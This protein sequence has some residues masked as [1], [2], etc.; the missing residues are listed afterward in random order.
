MD[1]LYLLVSHLIGR[2]SYGSDSWEN[3]SL[4]SLSTNILPIALFGGAVWLLT[5]HWDEIYDR[6]VDQFLVTA[7]FESSNQAYGWI[8]TW[9]SSQPEWA[10]LR[11]VQVASISGNGDMFSWIHRYMRFNETS[12]SYWCRP[13]SHTKMTCRFEGTYVQIVF[14]DPTNSGGFYVPAVMIVRVLGFDRARL[15]RLL[16]EAQKMYK[17]TR[18]GLQVWTHSK[19]HGGEV[20]WE[21]WCVLGRRSIETLVL[22]EEVKARSLE[23]VREFLS[24]ESKQ[25]YKDNSLPYRRG[26]LF[27]G[28]PGSGK[29]TLIHCIANELDREVCVVTLSAVDD[30]TLP[31]LLGS[32]PEKSVVIME[33]IDVAIQDFKTA[34]ESRADATLNRDKQDTNRPHS[35]LT[36]SGLL[37]AIDGV[38]SQNGR[39]LFV[40]TNKEAALDPALTRAGRLDVHIE[41]FHAKS[42]HAAQLFRRFYAIPSAKAKEAGIS[43]S[44]ETIDV[45][46]NRFA[47]AIPDG[48]L[49]MAQL[50]NYLMSHKH[51]PQKACD[52][53][54]EWVARELEKAEKRRAQGGLATNVQIDTQAAPSPEVALLPS[55]NLTVRSIADEDQVNADVQA[56]QFRDSEIGSGS[57]TLTLPSPVAY[58]DR[59]CPQGGER[60]Q[61][62]A[63]GA[64]SAAAASEETLAGDGEAEPKHT[65]LN[66]SAAEAEGAA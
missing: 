46:A 62:P 6:I 43:H 51:E 65:E 14:F 47:E 40:T 11:R 50:Q 9:A 22:D 29:T 7:S 59:I 42:A 53:A 64:L 33:D 13:T 10:K 45:L 21:N 55:A 41:F 35:G 56:R 28:V 54:R 34:S 44:S 19:A 37:N 31:K 23:D 26:Y 16:D 1:V 58:T 5:Q 20:E 48:A 61:D 2:L 25:W 3:F 38:T 32:T 39:V 66:G 49:A 12:K 60:C 57:S 30:V 36:L 8:Q 63:R 4:R 15:D 27:Y 17:K 52:G 24:P 18:E